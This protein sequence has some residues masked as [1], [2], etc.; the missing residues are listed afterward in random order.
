MRLFVLMKWKKKMNKKETLILRREKTKDVIYP[1]DV[2][3]LSDKTD[4]VAYLNNKELHRWYWYEKTPN[5]GCQT[6]K[7]NGIKFPCIWG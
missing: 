7:I 5:S 4:T 1:E 3:L 2:Q 6:V